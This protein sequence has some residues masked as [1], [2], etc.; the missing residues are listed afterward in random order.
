MYFGNTE[1]PTMNCI[2]LHNNVGLISKVS[3]EITSKNAEKLPV[4]TTSLSLKNNTMQTIFIH[5]LNVFL[6]ELRSAVIEGE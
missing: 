1:K 2:S 4:T 6:A 5:R 3:Q